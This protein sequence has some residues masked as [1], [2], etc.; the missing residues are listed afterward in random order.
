MKD[1]FKLGKSLKM[2]VLKYNIIELKFSVEIF[3]I[4]MT[5]FFYYVKVLFVFLGESL[6]SID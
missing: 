3:F 1:I 5:E 4:M 2:S 6:N